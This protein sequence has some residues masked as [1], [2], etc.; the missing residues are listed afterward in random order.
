MFPSQLDTNARLAQGA[1]TDFLALARD[2]EAMLSRIAEGWQMARDGHLAMNRVEN[3]FDAAE[4]VAGE[5][6]PD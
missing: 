1:N 4:N 3:I 2:V 5:L 6:L